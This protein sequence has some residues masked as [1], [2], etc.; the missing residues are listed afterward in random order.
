M[1]VAMAAIRNKHYHQKFSQL[2]TVYQALAHGRPMVMSAE[3]HDL[4]KCLGVPNLYSVHW[5]D[6]AGWAMAECIEKVLL[7]S[8]GA[9][10]ETMQ[11]PACSLN[12][13]TETA[14]HSRMVM[15]STCE[16]V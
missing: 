15:H 1:T 16:C 4:F 6:S 5:N 10:V 9:F 11:F 8:S 14:S 12:E 2:A 3:E 13:S 7:Q